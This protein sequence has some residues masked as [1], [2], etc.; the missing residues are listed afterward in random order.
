LLRAA[1]TE[2]IV[3]TMPVEDAADRLETLAATP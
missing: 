2:E 1:A 3:T